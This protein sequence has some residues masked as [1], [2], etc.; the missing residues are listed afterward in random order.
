MKL[1]VIFRG[2]RGFS[3]LILTLLF[4]LNFRP[5]LGFSW[6]QIP[7]YWFFD[8]AQQRSYLSAPSTGE[9]IVI[10]G[11]NDEDLQQ[12]P[13][14]IPDDATLA[15]LLIKISEQKPKAIGLDIV[16][17]KPVG[18]GK[19]Q[20]EEVFRNT[21]NLYGIGKF[22]GISTDS[23]FQTISPPPIL[24]AEGRV[25]D[26]SIMVDS[27]GVVRRGNLIPVADGENTIPSLGLLL[28]HHY[29]TEMGYEEK[30][31]PSGDLQ[32]GKTVFPVFNANDGGYVKAD[33]SGYQILMNWYNPPQSLPIVSL[34]D[35][36]A[37]NIPG[38]LFTDKIVL[39]GYS[40]IT[41]KQNVTRSPFSSI[42][43]SSTPRS[44]FGVEVQAN[45]VDY[46][47]GTVIDNQPVLRAIP[48]GLETLIISL[49]IV[50]TGILIW[51]IKRV[52]SPLILS[53]LGLLI[54]WVLSWLYWQINYQIFTQGF[55]LPIFPVW[56]ILLTGITSLFYLFRERILEQI[57]GLNSQIK[58]KTAQLLE[59][60]QEL[61]ETVNNLNQ[62][63]ATVQNQQE[64]LINQEKLAFLGRLTAGFCHQFKSPFYSLKYTFQTVENI[65]D[66]LDLEE[67]YVLQREE[68]QK[69]TKLI[70]LVREEE[71]SIDKLELLFKL[72]LVSPAR[73][74]L[75]F[76][77]A[78][79][80]QF[81]Q[82]ITASVIK[83]HCL[84]DSSSLLS[85]I[86]FDLDSSLND[87]IKIPQ[88]L[89][90]PLYNLVDNGVDAI[91][92]RENQEEEF[93]GVIKIRTAKRGQCWQITVED[94]GVGILPSIKNKL[95][96][97][98][99]SS[100]S[101]ANGIGLGL[102]MSREIMTNFIK[103]TIFIQ[104]DNQQT[105]FCLNIPFFS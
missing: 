61:E 27:D 96:S 91:L 30:T 83:F 97:P 64:Q 76:L 82:S 72:I 86:D 78:S 98:F 92:Q 32:I 44:I 25:G 74:T 100:K 105:K 28:A 59:Q 62:A 79:P 15:Q 40:T 85:Q 94:N 104:E 87:K 1:S 89:E 99:V 38:N 101:E 37:D 24:E 10:V 88:Q 70:G 84:E 33:D 43:K 45:L 34:S 11:I 55:W 8:Y 13:S 4:G 16:R 65:L 81:V 23:Y 54:V 51:L 68:Q 75:S 69:L 56:A 103:G 2:K 52:K 50:I 90:I 21:D 35:V 39:I 63:L 5:L 53:L 73:K 41:Y 9:R 48:N 47:L 42:D 12:F 60:N 29:L 31:A 71:K 14:T 67:D 93:T 77:E 49:P 58:Q 46:L 18:V 22:T 7:E 57:E 6:L 102:W 26:A 3:V 80:N 20:L 17:D 66:S 36:L 19:E 95:F